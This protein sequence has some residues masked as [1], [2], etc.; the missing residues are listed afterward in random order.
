MHA[1]EARIRLG[2]IE[3]KVYQL[4]DGEYLLSQESSCTA[5]GKTR[6]SILRVAAGKSDYAENLSVELKSANSIQ[7]EGSRARIK[8]IPLKAAVIFWSYWADKGSGAAGAILA[9]AS[10][11]AVVRRIDKAFDVART[12]SSY[13][14][15]FEENRQQWEKEYKQAIAQISDAIEAEIQGIEDNDFFTLQEKK[16]AAKDL[17]AEQGRRLKSAKA[18]YEPMIAMW[19]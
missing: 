6:D 7:V 4:P 2:A 13:N 1:K 8:A 12:E 19:R 17:K 3:L 18:D 9:A 11:E 10:L 16:D 14:Q 15:Q 5:I